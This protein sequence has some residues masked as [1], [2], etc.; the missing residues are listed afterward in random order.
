M[1]IEVD[2]SDI[3]FDSFYVDERCKRVERVIRGNEDYA[4]FKV[5]RHR[6]EE[7]P[8]DDMY[9]IMDSTENFWVWMYGWE[10][11]ALDDSEILSYVTVTKE[12]SQRP[13]PTE[14]W[15]ILFS[16]LFALFLSFVLFVILVPEFQT[17]GIILGIILL[18]LVAS[19]IIG[20]IFNRKNKA[21]MLQEKEYEIGMMTRHPLFIEVI[22]KFAA[23]DDISDLQREEYLRRIS[24]IEEKMAD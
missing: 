2:I 20:A 23:L 18:S 11:D 22:R 21:H 3:P 4:D 15:G 19:L 10:V 16:F 17:N 8:N 7:D 5:K 6:G 12:T 9:V 13:D 24:E 1:K 14:N